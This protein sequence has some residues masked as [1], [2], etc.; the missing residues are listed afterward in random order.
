MVQLLYTSEI[1]KLENRMITL[2][3]RTIKKGL[4][5][6]PASVIDRK[7]KVQF[8][9]ASFR[10]G[11]D[12]ILNDLVLFAADYTDIELTGSVQASYKTSYAAPF[13]PVGPGRIG[14]AADVLPLTEEFVLRSSELSSEVTASIIA[15]LKDEGIYELHPDQLELRIRDIWNGEKYKSKRFARTFSAEVANGTALQRYKQNKVRAWRFSALIDNKTSWQ[16]RILNG[17]IFYTESPESDKYRPPLHHHCRSGMLPVTITEEIDESLVFENRDFTQLVDQDQLETNVIPPDL[18]EKSFKNVDRYKKEYAIDK[19]ILQED[20]EKR[21]FKLKSTVGTSPLTKSKTIKKVVKPKKLSKNEQRV[22]D[23]EKEL[24]D[25]DAEKAGVL[26]ELDRVNLELQEIGYHP[27][28]RDSW[29]LWKLKD[30]EYGVLDKKWV[31]LVDKKDLLLKEKIKLTEKIAKQI[32]A[33]SKRDS[34]KNFLSR[35]PPTVQSKADDIIKKIPEIKKEVEDRSKSIITKRLAVRDAQYNLKIELDY[36]YGKLLDDSLSGK[37]TQSEF[38]VLDKELDTLRIKIKEYNREIEALV[39]EQL[40]NMNATRD[41][42]HKILYINEGTPTKQFLK[43]DRGIKGTSLEATRKAQ[44][45]EALNFFNKVMTQELRESMPVIEISELG[46]GGRAYTSRGA[47][48]VW[49][50]DEDAVDVLIHELGHNLEF[51]NEF[52]EYS[53]TKHLE[54]RTKGEAAQALKDLLGGNYKDYEVTKKDSFFNAYVGKQ[55]DDKST[56]VTSM[57]LQYLYNDPV[58]LYEKDPELFTWIVNVIRG[59]YIQ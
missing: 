59:H 27:E 45:D 32:I 16:C 6:S 2:I 31:A 40:K 43:M 39:T 8:R 3:D 29:A 51:N 48:M 35:V 9:A 56:E 11:A 4:F 10:I 36:K 42:I 41:E 28:D 14:A 33:K 5:G 55:Y 18:A 47:N 23:I 30:A 34:L 46:T 49:I 26:K 54:S 12:A 19:F 17:T 52:L 24:A 38:D 21:L 50:A 15:E 57:A 7:V 37:I 25:L 44:A 58:T 53:A 20:I 13:R 22:K 1:R